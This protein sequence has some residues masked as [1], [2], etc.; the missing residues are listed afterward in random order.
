VDSAA[1]LVLT[2]SDVASWVPADVAGVSFVEQP[3]VRRTAATESS[4]SCFFIKITS[5]FFIVSQDLNKCNN[6]V[7][8]MWLQIIVEFACAGTRY[9]SG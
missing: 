9:I 7:I 4:A 3:E 6:I 8:T 1:E 5:F 2:L